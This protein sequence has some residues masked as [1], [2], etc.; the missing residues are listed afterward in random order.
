MFEPSNTLGPRSLSS[1]GMPVASRGIAVVSWV[2]VGTSVK[3]PSLSA[4]QVAPF[5]GNLTLAE[6]SSMMSPREK[7]SAG[8]SISERS[9]SGARYSRSPSRSGPLSAGNEVARPKSPI[10]KVPSK[11]I[12]MLAGFRS[13]WIYPASCICRRPYQRFS[14]GFEEVDRMILPVRSPALSSKSENRRVFPSGRHEKERSQD[15]LLR[16]I[17]SG[18]RDCSYPPNCR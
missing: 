16:R 11:V 12:R 13:R 7:M 5:S 3:S 8:L 1:T 2:R 9:A 14:H 15:Y 6:I 4:V 10:F 17:L 18:C